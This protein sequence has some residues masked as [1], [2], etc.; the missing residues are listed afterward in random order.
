MNPVQAYLMQP[1]KPAEE[2]YDLKEDPW[3]TRNLI[4]DPALREEAEKLRRVLRQWER[5][6][7]D[8]G[9]KPEPK[10]NI[11]KK[12]QDTIEKRLQQLREGTGRYP[13]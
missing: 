13:Q 6:S 5:E 11:T 2:L 8:Q 9:R 12:Y 1:R 3:E 10:G 7:N 4:G